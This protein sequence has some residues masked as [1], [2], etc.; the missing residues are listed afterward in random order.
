MKAL[1]LIDI[2]NDYF[3]RGANPLVGSDKASEMARQVLFFFRKENLPVIHIQHISVKKDSNFFLEG[4]SGIGINV[5]VAPIT[6]EK[7]FIKHFPNA[8]M[9]TGLKEY[10]SSIETKD[11]VVCGM[12]THMCIDSTVRS[13]KDAGYK[14]QLIGD[15]CATKDLKWNDE[16]IPASYVQSSFLSA[17]NGSFADVVRA[18]KLI[19]STY[20]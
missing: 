16:V 12:M 3:E 1:V 8:F 19:N 14:I 4:T 6:G 17:L 15:A 7:I 2:Q 20:K 11:L 9:E 5:K 10:L 13:A 18:S